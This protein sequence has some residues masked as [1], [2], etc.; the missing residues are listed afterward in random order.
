MFSR[1]LGP[2][3]PEGSAAQKTKFGCLRY[4]QAAHITEDSRLLYLLIK[5]IKNRPAV[6]LCTSPSKATSMIRGQYQRIVD[7]I[8]DDPILRELS[9]P[10]PKLNN[11]CISKFISREEKEM[12]LRAAVM[13]KVKPHTKI[14]S[15]ETLPDAPVLLTSLPSPARPQVQYPVVPHIVGKRRGEKRRLDIEEPEAVV[16]TKEGPSPAQRSI[17]PRPIASLAVPV[18]ATS[19]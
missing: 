14:L 6:S 8:Q 3:S 13:P 1:C 9:I 12:N 15:T 10:F 17:Q 2:E 11:K 4:A 7:R 16:T 18:G 5:I 19:T